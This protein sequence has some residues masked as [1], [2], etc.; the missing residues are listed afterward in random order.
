MANLNRYL[1]AQ[2]I[3]NRSAV[4]CGLSAVSDVFASQDPAIVQLRTLLTSAGQT[5]IQDYIWQR[6]LM[7]YEFTALAGD[8]GTYDLPADFSY[9]IDQTGWQQGGPAIAPLMGPA[10]PQI[11]SYLKA[12]SLYSVSLYVW[13]RIAEGKLELYPQPVVSD[14]PISYQYV[15]R[16]W[17]LAGD[18]TTLQDSVTNNGD[19]VLFEPIMIVNFLNLKFLTAKGFD[20]T[21]ATQNFQSSLRSWE[22]KDASAPILNQGGGGLP[23][24][25]LGATTNIGGPTS[26]AADLPSGMGYRVVEIA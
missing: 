8:S 3:V 13:F 6:L 19:T 23:T 10:S 18:L 21:S 11:W 17:V 22:G 25:L 14:V 24:Y 15:S 20:T 26:G 9:M 1:T 4:E 12:S 2:E 5:L 16:G 7:S